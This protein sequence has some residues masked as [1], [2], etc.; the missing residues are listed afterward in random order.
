MASQEQFGAGGS[1]GKP[2]DSE[3]PSCPKCQSP[4]TVKQVSPV[5]FAPDIDDVIYGC[6]GCA[7]EFK[8]SVKRA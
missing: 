2:K 4:M 5:L 6:E 1:S 8:R 7:T 3:V